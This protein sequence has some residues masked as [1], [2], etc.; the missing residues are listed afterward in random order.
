MFTTHT[1]R[2]AYSH[3]LIAAHNQGF[4]PMA[5]NQFIRVVAATKLA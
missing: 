1:I 5:F 4:T 2:L 3:H